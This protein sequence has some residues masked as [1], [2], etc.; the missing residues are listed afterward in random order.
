MSGKPAARLPFSVENLLGLSRSEEQQ[1]QPLQE[2]DLPDFSG[3]GNS[4]LA[5]CIVFVL[6]VVNFFFFFLI[7]SGLIHGANF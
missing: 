6:T 7:F 3:E 1:H 5:I 2:Q 4:L